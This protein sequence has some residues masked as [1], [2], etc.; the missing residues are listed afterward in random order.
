MELRKYKYTQGEEEGR[1]RGG[2]FHT[3]NTKRAKRSEAKSAV[4]PCV[5]VP[6]PRGMEILKINLKK[7]NGGI[8]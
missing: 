8:I 3:H 1:T 5:C 7:T 2:H 4:D 6:F